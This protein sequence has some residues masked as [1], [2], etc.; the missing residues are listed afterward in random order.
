VDAPLPMLK[1]LTPSSRFWSFKSSEVLL[2]CSVSSSESFNA[3]KERSPNKFD[4]LLDIHNFC[5]FYLNLEMDD[6]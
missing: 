2:D 3:V 6:E 4:Y 1:I 5:L